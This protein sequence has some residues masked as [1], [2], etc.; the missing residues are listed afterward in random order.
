MDKDIEKENIDELQNV[1]ILNDWRVATWYNW[2]YS[3]NTSHFENG[4]K[5]ENITKNITGR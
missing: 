1:I 3:P 2:F 5:N 4:N